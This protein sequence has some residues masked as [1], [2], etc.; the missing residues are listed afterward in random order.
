MARLRRSQAL[1]DFRQSM[2]VAE[3]LIKKE[4]HYPDPAPSRSYKIAQGLRGGAIVIMVAAFESYLTTA[5]QEYLFIFTQHPI[6]FNPAKVPEIMVYNSC[7]L[8]LEK[9]IK[10]PYNPPNPSKYDKIIRYRAASD[11]VVKG[12]IDSSVFS[13]MA[14]NNPSPEKVKN[15]FKNLGIQDVFQN[16]KPDFDTRWGSPTS[17]NFIQDRLKT[18]IDRRHEVAHKASTLNIS[19]RD[20]EEYLKFIKI[21]AELCDETL[22]QHIRKITR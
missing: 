18:L 10:D 21:L 7:K 22:N 15:L 14:K 2:T 11:I 9:S 20:L 6:R 8:C 19:R 5:V 4:R 17:I 3:A 13:D 12:L 1:R 16:I